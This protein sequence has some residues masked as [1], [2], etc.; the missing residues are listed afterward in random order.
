MNEKRSS[1][2]SSIGFILASAGSAIGLGN[3]WKFPGK[4]GEQGGGT[5]ILVYLLMLLFVGFALML[6]EIAL[7]R[8]THKN[9]VGAYKSLKPKYSFMGML[10]ILTCFVIL[11]YYS[12]VG[13]WVMKYVATYL[14]GADFGGDT[15]VYFTSFIGSTFEPLI[16][17]I[18]FMALVVSIVVKGVAG[19]IEKASK[20]LMPILFF[21]L[22]TI[23]VRAVTLPGAS[24]GLEFLMH[25][26]LSTINPEMTIVALGQAF[27]SLSV[28]MGVMITY[29]S[30]VSKKDNLPKSVATIVCLDTLIAILS[31][32][33]IICAVFVTDKSLIGEQGGGFAFIS[34]PNVFA[35]LPGGTF[36][37]GLFFVLLFFAALTSA[38]SLLESC[39][40]FVT[41]ELHV[42]RKKATAIMATLAVILGCGYSLSN[43][44][45]NLQLPWFDFAEGLRM[46]PMCTVMEMLTDN[47]LIPVS[48][49]L[50][51]IFIG[52]IIK[53]NYI[54]D[55]IRSGGAKFGTASIW[56]FIIKFVCPLAIMAVLFTAFVLGQGLS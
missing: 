52:W 46:L 25:I 5:F 11:S 37:G 49:L 45:M 53:P 22:I 9:P 44:A 55:E 4:V 23:A 8:A 3:I 56:A 18:I 42:P 34:L 13:G 28:G 1:W 15:A 2:G 39:V 41:E 26:D 30:Y 14:T 12:V 51:C 21:L 29:G 54:I 31:G 33:A 17:H 35:T 40:S 38:I 43:G 10:A 36:F 27:F 7:G 47:L 48:A 50:T 32:V 16:W 19:G 20:F 24:E 6:G